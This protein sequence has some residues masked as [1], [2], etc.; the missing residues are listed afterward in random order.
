MTMEHLVG[1]FKRFMNIILTNVMAV[2]CTCRLHLTAAK[3]IKICHEIYL[4]NHE[5]Y[6]NK[7]D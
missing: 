1:E 3:L 2:S 7:I 5:I 4:K 6:F